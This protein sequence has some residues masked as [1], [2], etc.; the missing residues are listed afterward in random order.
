M[1]T[2]REVEFAVLLA[3]LREATPG[4]RRLVAV[5]GPPGA[6]KSTFA[7][8]LVAALNDGAP[9]HAALLSMDGFHYDDRVLNARGQRARKGA[10][11]TFDVDGLAALLARLAADDGREIAVPVFDREIE[12]AR[13]G[14]AIV[15]AAARIV[16]VEGNY[17]LLDDAAW[18]PLRAMFDTTVMLAVPR[19]VLIERLAAR[20]QGYGMDEAA[21][22]A[23]LDGNDLPNVDLVLGGSVPADFL[24]ANG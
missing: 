20:W 3:Q 21:I 2:T 7:A 18:A 5:A 13:A 10:P 17:L 23:K 6:G 12:I 1:S 19:A 16:V 22:L 14:A 4:A 8:R 15:P 11:H 9:G 24:V